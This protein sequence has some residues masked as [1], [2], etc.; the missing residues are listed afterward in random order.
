M[1]VTFVAIF[2]IA[3]LAMVVVLRVGLERAKLRKPD[4]ESEPVVSIIVAARNEERYIGEC[5]ESLLRLDYPAEKLD[6]IIVNDNSTDGTRALAETTGRH[7]PHVRILDSTPASGNLRGKANALAQGI[8]ASRGDI[9]MLTDADCV[10]PP[11]WVRSTLE[12]FSPKVGVVGGFTLLEA[13]TAFQTVQMLDWILL[14]GI[15]SATAGWGRPLTVIGNNFS[16]RRTAYDA[17]GG[18]RNIPFSVTEDY[19]LVRAVL[20]H[21]EFEVAF[22]AVRASAVRSR[23]CENIRQ[24]F[25]QKQRWGVG[26]LDMVWLGNLVM[27]V[28]W[29]ARLS[30]VAGA[31]ARPGLPVLLSGL[32]VVAADLRFVALLLKEFGALRALRHFLLFEVYV[33]VYALIIPFVAFFS[34]HIVWKE[35][36]L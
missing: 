25:R 6:I 34:K 15:S 30:V 27:L 12:A 21:T 26:G 18:Y 20:R 8:D 31:V 14:F 7:Q 23:A 10:V 32:A 11:S 28:T 13:G 4:A 19:A 16:I 36:T 35:R 1:F 22:P 5:L 2:A 3:Y 9:L 17:T 29:L 33:T 24:L